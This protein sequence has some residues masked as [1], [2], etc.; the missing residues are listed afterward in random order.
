MTKKLSYNHA[1]WVLLAAFFLAACSTSQK[2]VVKSSVPDI[3]AGK[4]QTTVSQTTTSLG[5]PTTTST[6]PPSA[7]GIL[8]PILSSP[9]PLTSIVSPA[10]SNEGLWTPV[11]R[12]VGN[13]YALYIT[14]L[15]PEANK[16]LSG[17]AWM[18]PKLLF[19]TL[20][21][22]SISPGGY[23]WKYTAP[24]EPP[25]QVNLVA[26][27]N[28]GFKMADSGGGYFSEGKLVDP[29]RVGSASLVIYK[30][31][32]I[33]VGQWGR[34]VS[35]T[36]NVVA[37]RQNLGLLVDHGQAVPGLNPNDIIQWGSTLGN[38]PNVWR[39]GVG[40]TQS[41]ALVYVAGPDLTIVDL[42]QLMV[43][44]HIY[45]GMELDINPYW[46]C[47]AYYTPV[48][49]STIATPANGQVLLSTM[50]HGP[51][52]FF[53]PSWARDFITMSARS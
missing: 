39:S 16:P 13:N 49:P 25:Q 14:Y 43:A 42:A 48:A 45:T 35:M 52:L 38:I 7:P 30:D 20:Y 21:S 40:I 3:N 28:G 10:L 18:D 26:A 53:Q 46:P 8:A 37:V 6:T 12:M 27:F 51:N 2:S 32:T 23:G 15:R 41:G 47:F 9:A 22:G 4:A 50:A 31:G 17:I 29:L 1:I 36:P 19:A 44:A 11:G 34:D 24:I 33:T 5:L